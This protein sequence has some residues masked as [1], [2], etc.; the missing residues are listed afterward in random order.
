MLSAL[1]ETVGALGVLAS[2]AAKLAVLWKKY[3]RDVAAQRNWR[4]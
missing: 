2:I 3:Q 4:R 1:V